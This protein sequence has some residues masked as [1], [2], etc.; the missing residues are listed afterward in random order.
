MKKLWE[1]IKKY[2]GFVASPITLFF[3]VGIDVKYKIQ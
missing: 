1:L 3:I 2:L